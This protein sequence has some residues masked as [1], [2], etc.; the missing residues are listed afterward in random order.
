MTDKWIYNGVEFKKG[1]YVKIARFEESFAPN[2]MGYGREWDNTWLQG[3]MDLFIGRTATIE[4]IDDYG[5]I[6]SDY[7]GEENIGYAWP[8]SVLEKVE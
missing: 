8:L 6:F 3:T 7:E 5:V 2:G 4:W 1:D